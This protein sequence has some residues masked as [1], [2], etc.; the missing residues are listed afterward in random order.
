MNLWT[1]SHSDNV[2]WFPV[3]FVDLSSCV[4]F[5]FPLLVFVIFLQSLLVMCFLPVPLCSNV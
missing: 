3:L 4:R 5:Y 1:F 2:S